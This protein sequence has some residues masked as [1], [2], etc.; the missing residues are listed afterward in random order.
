MEKVAKVKE[1]VTPLNPVKT[2]AKKKTAS[3]VKKTTPVSVKKTPSQKSEETRRRAVKTPKYFEICD[4]DTEDS[5]ENSDDEFNPSQKNDNPND[6]WNASSDEDYEDDAARIKKSILTRKS[7]RGELVFVPETPAE[8]KQKRLDDFLDRYEYTKPPAMPSTDTPRK[9]SKRKLFTHS[10]FDDEINFDSTNS[11]DEVRT[12][13][14]KEERKENDGNVVNIDMTGMFFPQKD[15]KTKTPVVK[16][17]PKPKPPQTPKVL[18]NVGGY[19]F[20]KSL[21]VDM[22][23]AMC[24]SEALYYRTNYKTKK[25]ELTEK[26]FKLYDEKVFDGELK[27]VPV[28]WNKKLLNTAG[29]CN[30]SRRNGVKRSELELSEKV[31]TSADRLRCTLIHEMCHAATWVSQFDSLKLNFV[32]IFLY[33]EDSSW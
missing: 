9:P 11:D 33:F 28:K 8:V 13:K 18:S 10:H 7:R 19:S 32:L 5:E 12:A 31:L 30:N 26:L 2:T 27:D 16:R 20:L 24:N 14:E 3:S 21:D 4:T 1:F 17:T 15:T 22:N 23:P 6:T 29:R 25:A